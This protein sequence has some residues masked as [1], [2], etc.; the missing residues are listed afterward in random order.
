[1]PKLQAT[2]LLVRAGHRVKYG[3]V[4]RSFCVA[5]CLDSSSAFMQAG[6]LEKVEPIDQ[7]AELSAD[8]RSRPMVCW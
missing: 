4:I 3:A 2:T 1:M 6:F 8:A 5:E 7:P